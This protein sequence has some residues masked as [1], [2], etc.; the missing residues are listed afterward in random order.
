MMHVW[1][2]AVYHVSSLRGDIAKPFVNK[3]VRQKDIMCPTVLRN[4]IRGRNSLAVLIH[5]RHFIRCG[6]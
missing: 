5:H 4:Y 2:C 6:W 1:Y 3:H